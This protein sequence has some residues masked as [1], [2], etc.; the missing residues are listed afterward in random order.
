[1]KFLKAG[2]ITIDQR[3]TFITALSLLLVGAS[4]CAAAT[5]KY[6]RVPVNLSVVHKISIGDAIAGDTGKKV[7]NSG[8]ALNLLTGRAANLRGVDLSSIWSEYTEDI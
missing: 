1:M 2:E 8:F 4:L 5:G 7:I 3:K 6:V